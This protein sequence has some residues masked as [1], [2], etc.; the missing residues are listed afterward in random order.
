MIEKENL[1]LVN[2]L[3]S[4]IKNNDESAQKELNDIQNNCNHEIG[5][6]LKNQHVS[7]YDICVYK[8]LNCSKNFFGEQLKGKDY[9]KTIIDISFLND[10]YDD[11]YSK[12]NRAFYLQRK[13]DEET[14]DEELSD[15]ISSTLKK[16]YKFKS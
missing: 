3:L 9:F 13:F 16:V 2:E 14:S 7:D 10:S 5:I 8:C 12:I 6:K 4:K 11:K 1:K 15:Q